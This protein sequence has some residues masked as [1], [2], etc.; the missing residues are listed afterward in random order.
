MRYWGKHLTS[1]PVSVTTM[2]CSNWAESLPSWVT[3]VQ[4][5]GQ[6]WSPHTPSEI[7]GS[8]V[9]QW[10]GWGG[11]DSV[12]EVVVEVVVGVVDEEGTFITPTA[13]FLA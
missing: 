10:P 11:G 13:L 2:V 1:T 5:S 12:E 7:I 3:E 6:V 4:L 8:M 9:K